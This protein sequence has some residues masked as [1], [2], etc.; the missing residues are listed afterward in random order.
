MVK[1]KG[2]DQENRKVKSQSDILLVFTDSKEHRYKDIK[3]ES[4]SN[5]PTLQKYLKEFIDVKIIKKR[6][7]I[8]S[9][10]YPYPVYYSLTEEGKLLITS[11]TEGQRIYNEIK[12]LISDNTESPMEVLDRINK[13]ANSQILCLL[14]AFKMIKDTENDGVPK[15]FI[16]RVLSDKVLFSKNILDFM[17]KYF[18]FLPYENIIREFLKTENWEFIDPKKLTEI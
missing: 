1:G 8:E 10:L 16:E 5:D 2:K 7:D 9:R 12:K 6:I 18:I 15:N 4:K 13:W 3:L 11:M 17:M 14:I